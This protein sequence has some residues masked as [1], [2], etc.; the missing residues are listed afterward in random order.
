MFL[1]LNKPVTSKWPP[2]H[3]HSLSRWTWLRWRELLSKQLT[4]L[5]PRP[6]PTAELGPLNVT[7]KD[8]FP[9]SVPSWCSGWG[10]GGSSGGAGGTAPT[11]LGRPPGPRQ[12]TAR[13]P[14]PAT[15]AAMAAVAA[16]SVQQPETPWRGH[17]TS[18]AAVP[19]Q[20]TP[21]IENCRQ[22]LMALMILFLNQRAIFS[23]NNLAVVGSVF[24]AVLG[25]T[26]VPLSAHGG[27]KTSCRSSADSR[28]RRPGPSLP[29]CLP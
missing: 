25:F 19:S 13:L 28:T 26:A 2:A 10:T 22:P 4:N 21:E 15:V 8:T 3:T 11:A 14:I 23:G 27:R 12:V 16:R 6:G 7:Q 5:F 29:L 18:G 1:H 17:R 24:S 9:L 20:Q